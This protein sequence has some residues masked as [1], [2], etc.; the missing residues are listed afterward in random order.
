MHI[1]NAIERILKVKIISSSKMFLEEEEGEMIIRLSG[2][3][4][5]AAGNNIKFNW[6]DI[7]GGGSAEGNAQ[8]STL[9]IIS[10]L[11]GDKER[12]KQ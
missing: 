8:C 9:M 5:R 4:V 3:L 10:F 12:Q 1:I 11:G 7:A 2:W 6:P